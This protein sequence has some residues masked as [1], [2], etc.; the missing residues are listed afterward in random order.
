MTGAITAAIVPQL[1]INTF[2]DDIFAVVRTLVPRHS[3]CS[4]LS[5]VEP[6]RSSLALGLRQTP[7]SC[8][9]LIAG[10]GCGGLISSQ[11][12]FMFFYSG[13][14]LSL[15]VESTT[16]KFALGMCVEYLMERMRPGRC[17]PGLKLK[18]PA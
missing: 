1:A 13:V 15:P 6:D 12:I 14:V 18:I 9:S 4:H 5:A 16:K 11:A 3:T 7:A 17:H 10:L 2:G 8:A